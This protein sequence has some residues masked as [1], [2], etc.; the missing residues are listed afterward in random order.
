MAFKSIPCMVSAF[1]AGYAGEPETAL[2]SSANWE[3]WRAGRYAKAAGHELADRVWSGRG[4]TV[5]TPRWAYRF[6]YL[7]GGH[8][9]VTVAPLCEGRDIVAPRQGA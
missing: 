8:A 7:R 6:A 3:A 2:F 4:N 9:A 1:A 5:R